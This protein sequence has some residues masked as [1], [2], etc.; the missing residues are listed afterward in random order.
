MKKIN[1][2][3]S[4]LILAA[5][6]GATLVLSGCGDAPRSGLVT[7]T[8]HQPSYPMTQFVTV[9]NVMVPVTNWV[10]EEWRIKIRSDE[11]GKVGRLGYRDVDQRT[12]DSCWIGDHY[13]DCAARGPH[14]PDSLEN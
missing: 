9:N 4:V 8:W 12:Y 2:G 6:V 10:P 13:P 5:T 14:R 1:S 7:D 3:G 11:K